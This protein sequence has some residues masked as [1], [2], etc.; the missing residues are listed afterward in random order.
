MNII[1]QFL[2]TSAMGF[3]FGIGFATSSWLLQR[4]FHIYIIA[5]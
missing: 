2:V 4:F 1:R 3:S 5:S